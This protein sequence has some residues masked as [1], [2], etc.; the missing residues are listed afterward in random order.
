[1]T[2]ARGA[3]DNHPDDIAEARDYLVLWSQR[4]AEID[5]GPWAKH[6][7]SLA[8]TVPF[9]YKDP[10]L[11]SSVTLFG[12]ITTMDVDTIVEREFGSRYLDAKVE[13]GWYDDDA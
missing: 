12:F 7:A 9:E 13:W 1:M 10:R 5:S 2:K 4:L 11:R 8:Q 6:I 3:F